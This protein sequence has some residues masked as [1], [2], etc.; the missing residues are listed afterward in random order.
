MVDDFGVKYVG[1]EYTMHLKQTLEENYTLP[2]NGT[3]GDTLSCYW[4]GTTKEDT[5]IYQC[6][7][8]WQRR[9]NNSN[10]RH[11]NNS[12]NHIQVPKSTVAQ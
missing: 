9:S 10:T 7:V 6:Q 8:T 4:I 2:L 5:F 3:V 12:I 1:K 11:K